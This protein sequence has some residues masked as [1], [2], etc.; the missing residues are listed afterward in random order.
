[1]EASELTEESSS[2]WWTIPRAKLKMRRNPLLTDLRVPLCGRALAVVKRRLAA[3]PRGWLFPSRGASG[4]IE[5]KALGVAVWCHMP[6]CALRPEWERPRLPVVAWSPHDLRRTTR[7]LLAALGCPA[8][9]AEVI[10]G[11]MLPGVQGVYDRHSYDSERRLWLMTLDRQ[12]Q[13]LA[14]G[15]DQA[16]GR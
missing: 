9:I 15:Q 7:T 4:H 10:L 14:G 11:H 13:Q 8:E 2:W 6:E 5:Q 16:S 12:L 3:R 1:M